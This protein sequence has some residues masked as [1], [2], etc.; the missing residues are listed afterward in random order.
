MWLREGSEIKFLKTNRL[1]RVTGI[2]E[3]PCCFKR[4]V[5]VGY[6]QTDKKINKCPYCGSVLKQMNYLYYRDDEM[7]V[8]K[9]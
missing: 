7:E 9:L 5:N 1:G 2:E 3:S 6:K 4:M 8:I